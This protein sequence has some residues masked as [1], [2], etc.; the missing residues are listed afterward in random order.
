MDF[1][2]DWDDYSSKFRRFTARPGVRLLLE[3]FASLSAVQLLS[4]LLPLVA[5]PYLTR[6]LGAERFGL[7]ASA[8]S[9]AG[10]FAY[11]TNYGFGTTATRQ[12]SVH[13]N[14]LRYISEISSA[15]LIIKGALLLFS[16][17]LFL[18]IIAFAPNLRLEAGLYLLI[19]GVTAGDTLYPQWLFQGLEKMKLI[20]VLNAIGKA[21]TFL[22]IILLISQPKDYLLYAATL[23]S[24]Q[25]AVGLIG[26]W[27][28]WRTGI[29]FIAPDWNAITAQIHEGWLP[30]LSTLSIGFYTQSRLFIFSFFSTNTLLGYYAFAD[31]AAGIAQVF[32]IS[33]LI[34]AVLPRLTFMY[35]QNP[36]R[37]RKL[38]GQLYRITFLY[39][40]VVFPILA[41]FANEI[42]YLLSGHNYPESVISF[43][44]LLVGVFFAL[45]NA[46]RVYLLVAAGRFRT[47]TFV[48]AIGS[49]AGFSMM[50][51]LTY[52]LSYLGMA[53]SAAFTEAFIFALT[54]WKMRTEFPPLSNK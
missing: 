54:S 7:T 29:R 47:F 20:S 32:P 21:I 26:I 36:E 48:H 39:L 25:I 6:A 45:A 23:S 27:A 18:F 34:T 8:I 52:H 1:R 24:S 44:I 43:R 3:N 46:F 33:A 17:C 40:I 14:N 15:I 16:F 50:M 10:L 38:F 2:G 35:S 51:I 4:Y 53:I 9:F 11:L 31:K 22:L 30:F 37:A 49:V 28:A 13:R 12:I 19:F 42:I 5:T 41:L